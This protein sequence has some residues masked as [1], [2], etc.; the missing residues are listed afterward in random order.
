MG[1]SCAW[2]LQKSGLKVTLIDCELP[3]QSCSFGNAACLATS[4]LVPFSY[5]GLI[6]KI[7]G[8]LFDPLGPMSIRWKALPSLLPWFWHFWR[9]SNMEK[10]EEVAAAQANLMRNVFADY[11]EILQATGS[12][13]LKQS[14]GTIHIFDSEK[15]YKAVAW[16]YELTGRLGFKAR[17]LAPAE[18][19][20]LVPCLKLDGG[21]ALM[22][23]GWH[24]LLNPAKVTA[25]IV[26]Y[27]IKQGTT[28]IQDRVTS[29]SAGHKGVLVQT[30]SGKSI[31]AD[32]LVVAAGAWSNT[33]AGQLD[34]KVPL[35]GKRGYHSQVSD[36]GIKLQHPVMSVSRAF[37]MTPMEDGLRFAGTAEFAP[38]DAQPDYRRAEILLKQGAAYLPGLK[39]GNATQWM[40]HRP[41]MADST[42]VISAS[43]S[44]SN[45]FYAFGHGHYGIT[46]G[47]T[48]GRLIA[49]LVNG[50]TPST[51]MTAYRMDRF[52]K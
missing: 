18:L 48:T 41:M 1:A 9:V 39:T 22:E 44:H 10:V 8:W 13:D 6:R 2:Y 36:P 19:E 45:V 7:P 31:E 32:Q 17:R 49:E 21:V 47:P 28:W 11:D 14:P 38:L 43:P 40:G 25:N 51:D 50:K 16:Q 52:T 29:T 34:F 30:E 20:S 42:P 15:D 33:F 27:C 3:G 5:P 46:Q 37:V 35:I 26:D 23:P 12:T 4:G 24:H